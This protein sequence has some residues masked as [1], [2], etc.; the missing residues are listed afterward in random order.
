MLDWWIYGLVDYCPNKSIYPV[1][2]QS[3]R[4]LA[5]GFSRKK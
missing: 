4:L 1:I 5:F 3:N 2:R